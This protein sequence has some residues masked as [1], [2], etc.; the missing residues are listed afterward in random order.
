M[1]IGIPNPIEPTID[2]QCF[3]IQ[4]TQCLLKLDYVPQI[5]PL[6]STDRCHIT[7]ERSICS[8]HRHAN[9]HGQASKELRIND[10]FALSI[11]FLR[12]SR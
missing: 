12:R 4:F 3:M 10:G 5:H 9:D 1:L 8:V 6:D 2:H 11:S 7:L